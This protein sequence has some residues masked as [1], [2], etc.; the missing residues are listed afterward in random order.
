MK[1]VKTETCAKNL[2]CT[3]FHNL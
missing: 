2:Y 1:Y 3:M